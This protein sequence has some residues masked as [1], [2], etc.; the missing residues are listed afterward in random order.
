[1]IKLGKMSVETKSD[2]CLFPEPL[3]SGFEPL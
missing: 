3:G 1:M 2:K